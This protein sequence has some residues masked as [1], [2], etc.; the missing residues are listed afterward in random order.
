MAATPPPVARYIYAD[1]GR[2]PVIQAL[3]FGLKAAV[4]AIVLEAVVRIGR[5]ALKNQA[6]IRAR[7]AG[8]HRH[9]LLQRAVPADR[10]RSGAHRLLRR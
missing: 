5:R 3:F 2:A 9:L 6:M 1:W 10:V 7:R 4:L 8:F